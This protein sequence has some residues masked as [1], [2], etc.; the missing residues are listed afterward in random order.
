MM[1]RSMMRG[2]ITSETRIDISHHSIMLIVRSPI[3]WPGNR[4]VIPA[5]MRHAALRHARVGVILRGPLGI[6]SR[7]ER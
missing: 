2:A 1:R 6:W 5:L 7:S 3:P 4:V